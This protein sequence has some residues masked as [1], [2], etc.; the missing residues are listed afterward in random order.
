MPSRPQVCI[1]QYGLRPQ[2]AIVDAIA[3]V[4]Y[5]GPLVAAATI[6][7]FVCMNS[8]LSEWRPGRVTE[9]IIRELSDS[10]FGVFLVH[11]AVLIALRWIPALAPASSSLWLTFVLWALTTAFSFGVVMVARRVPGVRRLV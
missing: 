4:G 7:V 3:P 9:R 11:F 5:Y 6:G 2:L 8:I 10:A 1:I